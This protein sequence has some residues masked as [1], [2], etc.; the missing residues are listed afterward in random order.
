MKNEYNKNLIL[1]IS[2]FW[3]SYLVGAIPIILISIS[4]RILISKYTF[5]LILLFILIILFSLL[6]CF[7]L[8]YKFSYIDNAIKFKYLI[9]P[10]KY[11]IEKEEVD[12]IDIIRKDYTVVLYLVNEEIVKIY[13]VSQN[14][15]DIFK[16]FAKDNNILITEN[17]NKDV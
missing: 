4:N 9:K 17:K 15:I 10:D 8:P 14:I 1:P 12:S 16:I 13:Y 11:I 2:I 6:L 3:F 7:A 5:I